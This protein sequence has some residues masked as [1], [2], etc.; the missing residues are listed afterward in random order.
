V[1][2]HG[3]SALDSPAPVLDQRDT[4]HAPDRAGRSQGRRQQRPWRLAADDCR[5][6]QEREDDEADPVAEPEDEGLVLEPRREPE[7]QQRREQAELDP[8]GDLDEAEESPRDWFRKR[9]QAGSALPI[10]A[11]STIRSC[12]RVWATA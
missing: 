9:A 6:D 7:E 8:R 3:G 1:S 2:T 11:V 5:Q 4:D 12:S 10:S